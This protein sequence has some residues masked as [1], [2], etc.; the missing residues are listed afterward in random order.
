M[1]I[2]DYRPNETFEQ[3]EDSKVAYDYLNRKKVIENAYLWGYGGNEFAILRI[4]DALRNYK[5]NSYDFVN[6]L[7]RDF[8]RNHSF[9]R[10]NDIK[11]DDEQLFVISFK[12]SLILNEI[13]GKLYISKMDYAIH[14]LEYTL[15]DEKRKL[16]KGQVSRHGIGFEV[17]F[18][19]ITE[20]KRKSEK[21]FPNYIS[22]FNNFKVQKA[23]LFYVEKLYWNGSRGLF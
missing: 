12:Q 1:R 21:M 4:H 22:F 8:I 18:E 11:Q 19:I 3:D 16:R 6:V 7:E 2:Y 17:V 14:K 13:V 5:I 20:Y 10:E 9:K 15:Y 23:P